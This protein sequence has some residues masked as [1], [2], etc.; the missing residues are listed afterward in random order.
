MRVKSFSPLRIFSAAAAQL[1]PGFTQKGD[2]L[3]L[4]YQKR[5]QMR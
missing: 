5:Y 1:M 3:N 2:H 4:R